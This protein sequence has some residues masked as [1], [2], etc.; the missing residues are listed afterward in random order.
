MTR[1]VSAFA[2]GGKC[3]SIERV[4]PFARSVVLPRN[5]KAICLAGGWFG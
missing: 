3:S 5:T 1:H 2:F 4:V